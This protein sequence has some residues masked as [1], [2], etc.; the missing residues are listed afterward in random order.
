MTTTQEETTMIN[1]DYVPWT[2]IGAVGREGLPCAP[3]GFRRQELKDDGGSVTHYRMV[4][5]CPVTTR[6]PVEEDGE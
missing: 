5:L 2:P 1:F 4:P 6:F 3:C